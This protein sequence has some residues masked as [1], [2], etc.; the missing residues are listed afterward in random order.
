M[1]MK[2]PPPGDGPAMTESDQRIKGNTLA[3]FFDGFKGG[4]TF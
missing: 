4:G 2:E 3:I 1:H